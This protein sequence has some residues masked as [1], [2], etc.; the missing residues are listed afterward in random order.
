MV[1]GIIFLSASGVLFIISLYYFY[2]YSVFEHK[3]DKICK[4]SGRL[5]RL[6]HKKN[7]PVYGRRRPDGPIR[8]LF[9][10]KDLSRGSYE[11]TVNNKK[12][13]ARYTKH[14]RANEMPLVADVIYLKNAP[15]IAYV[16]TVTDSHTFGFYSFGALMVGI[17]T[18]VLGTLS[19][20]K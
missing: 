4:T 8:I 3:P 1:L 17:M 18:S 19:L 10:I 5:I 14:S 16:K 12:Y 2:L 11:Y 7:V 20:L 6:K 15:R 9:I 13:K